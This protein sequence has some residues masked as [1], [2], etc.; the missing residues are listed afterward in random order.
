MRR[1]PP[2]KM[3][4]ARGSKKGYGLVDQRPERAEREF[5]YRGISTQRRNARP[6]CLVPPKAGGSF[7][8][9]TFL[10]APDHR[11]GLARGLRDLGRASTIGC[12]KDDLC[13]PNVLL[14]AIA[15]GDHSLKLASVCP[16]QLDIRSLV[17]ALDSHTRVLQG[18][19][20]RI[21]C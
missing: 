10:P 19:S 2:Q 13:P 21:E 9:E 7:L 8:V 14:R 11:L 3:R 5:L 6:S 20:K 4:N 16:A 1:V 18:N 15:V 17:H 12:Q